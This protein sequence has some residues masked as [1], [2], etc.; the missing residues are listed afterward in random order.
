MII[1]FSLHCIYSVYYNYVHTVSCKN[2]TL[3]T[4]DY[5]GI[6]SRQTKPLPPSEHALHRSPKFSCAHCSDVVLL[7]RLGRFRQYETSAMDQE[8]ACSVRTPS[9]TDLDVN[10]GHHCQDLQELNMSNPSKS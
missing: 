7:F 2:M 4:V 8:C 6:F 5:S 3:Y 10:S 9:S 1:F